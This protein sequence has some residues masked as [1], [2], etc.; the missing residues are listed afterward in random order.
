V[1]KV[2]TQGIQEFARE[3][4]KLDD[5]WIGSH[6]AELREEKHGVQMGHVFPLRAEFGRPLGRLV[7]NSK[8]VRR[9]LLPAPDRR[10]DR[11]AREAARRPLQFA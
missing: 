10:R 6:L 3:R 2:A 9:D 7:K 8:E 4:N 11:G 1:R 5:Q